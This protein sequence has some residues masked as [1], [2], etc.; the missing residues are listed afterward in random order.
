MNQPFG[1]EM[2]TSGIEFIAQDLGHQLVA[3]ET[4]MGI[5]RQVRHPALAHR[6]LE[7]PGQ[8][9]KG[10]LGSATKLGEIRR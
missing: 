3:F 8:V 4:P 5:G 7:R 9:Y 6:F 2:D 1:P 10:N